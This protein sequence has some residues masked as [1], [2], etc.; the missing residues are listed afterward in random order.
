MNKG[1]VSVE[2]EKKQGEGDEENEEFMIFKNLVFIFGF[3]QTVHLY[4]KVVLKFEIHVYNMVSY[5][6]PLVPLAI[7]VSSQDPP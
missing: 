6:S 1:D 4:E 7:R 2:T 3:L 5:Y